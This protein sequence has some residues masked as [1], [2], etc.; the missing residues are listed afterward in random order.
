MKYRALM[1]HA[2]FSPF[3]SLSCAIEQPTERTNWKNSQ[4]E[5]A[6]VMHPA[7]A[8]EQLTERPD[9][10]N[11]F[12]KFAAVGTILVVDERQ[13]TQATW[14]V[15]EARSRERYSPS[16]TFK[17]PHALIALDTGVV[18]DEFQIFPWDGRKRYWQSAN[19]ESWNQDQD[20]RSSMRNSV[21]W[22]YQEFA[23][24]I[25]ENRARSYLKKIDYGNADTSG[26][27]EGYWLDGNLSISAHEQISFLKRLYRTDLPLQVEH[28]RLVKDIM[29]VEAGQNWIL[30]GKT[31]WTGDIGWWVG[32]VE[33]PTGPV[34]FALHIDT[35]NGIEDLP[36][37]EGI[38][39]SILQS[40]NALPQTN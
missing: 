20:L 8:A 39:R 22:V 38:V 28:Q 32:W 7:C 29:I 2:V 4:P 19:L 6:F 11:I 27:T 25:G 14:V 5:V 15:D 21:I 9:W 40:I 1:L 35:P 31:G 3:I 13:D 36:K 17:I 34:F 18:R 16:S 33:Q 26:A 30:R 24:N 23:K 12:N 37:R 10:R